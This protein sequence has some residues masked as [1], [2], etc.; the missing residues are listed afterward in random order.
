MKNETEI[1]SSDQHI[2]NAVEFMLQ[3]A[4]DSRASDIHIE[5]KRDVSL[6]RFRID[7]VLH[8]IQT[9]AQGRARGGGLADQDH[10]APRHRREAPAAGRPGQDHPRR[11]RGRAARL[12]PAGGLRREG[13]D[14]HLRPAGADAGPHRRSA[15]TRTRWSIFNDFIS[16]PHGIILVTGPTGSG[17][18]TTLYSAL[19]AIATPRDQ[20]HHDRGPDRDGLR[21]V[22]PDRGAD[23]DRRSPSPRALRHILR[24]DPDVIMVGEIRDGETAQ[25]A[26]Q[27]A[28]TGHL[29]FSTLHTNDAAASISPPGRPR[30]RALPD[31]LDAGRLHG[32]APAAPHLPA[33][34]DRALPDRRGGGD[35]AP[36]RAAGQAGQG[37]GGRGLLRVPRHRLPRPHR[38]LRDPAHRRRRS[39]T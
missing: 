21:G 1:E 18:T 5:P 8:D 33:L 16:R 26:I 9:H 15:S 10:V 39:S 19:K 37:Q 3:H 20:R 28:L 34:R 29:V 23:Q 12:D 30:R 7:G 6:I 38:H 27:A 4:F 25:Y 35:P 2:V 31:Q 24:Q 36:R 32:A 14:A 17:K 11:P 13:G 22:Q